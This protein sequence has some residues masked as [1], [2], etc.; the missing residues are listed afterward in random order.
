MMILEFFQGSVGKT[1]TR[2]FS[3]PFQMSVCL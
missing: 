2:F 3:D 1:G